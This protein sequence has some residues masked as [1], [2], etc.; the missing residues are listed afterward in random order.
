MSINKPKWPKPTLYKAK[1][2]TIE[3]KLKSADFMAPNQPYSGKIR[4]VEKGSAK[5]NSSIS[6]KIED[7]NNMSPTYSLSDDSPAP[8]TGNNNN[9]SGAGV[10]ASKGWSYKKYPRKNQ[11]SLNC[12]EI[13]LIKNNKLQILIDTLSNFYDLG[14]DFLNTLLPYNDLNISSRDM[15]LVLIVTGSLVSA[16]ENFDE[17]WTAVMDSFRIDLSQ[18]QQLEDVNTP[19][20]KKLITNF[21]ALSVLV[22]LING[23][24]YLDNIFIGHRAIELYLQQYKSI[25]GLSNSNMFTYIINQRITTEEKALALH[26]MVLFVRYSTFITTSNQNEKL[27]N[28]KLFYDVFLNS[29]FTYN[30]PNQSKTLLEYIQEI[31][32]EDVSYQMYTTCDYYLVTA[33]CDCLYFEHLFN[34]PSFE[35]KDQFHKALITIIKSQNEIANKSNSDPNS[36]TPLNPFSHLFMENPMYDFFTI[37]DR[38]SISDGFWILLEISWLE[39]INSYYAESNSQ[40][41]LPEPAVAE[42]NLEESED[43]IANGLMGKEHLEELERS[44]TL[45]VDKLSHLFLI[46]TTIVIS[47]LTSPNKLGLS[48]RNLFLLVD[49]LSFQ[50]NIFRIEITKITESKQFKDSL[51]NPVLKEFYSIWNYALMSDA[52]QTNAMPDRDL[53][54][55]QDFSRIYFVPNAILPMTEYSANDFAFE[56]HS[57]ILSSMKFMKFNILMNRLI[58][59]STFISQQMKNAMI[60]IWETLQRSI[61]QNWSAPEIV[62]KK[63]FSYPTESNTNDKKNFIEVAEDNTT[64]KTDKIILPPPLSMTMVPSSSQPLAYMTQSQSFNTKNSFLGTIGTSMSAT[65]S[66]SQR[67]GS[68][69][70]TSQ[71]SNRY[72]IQPPVS[73]FNIETA[74]QSKTVYPYETNN[75]NFPTPYSNMMFNPMTRDDSLS[76]SSNSMNSR[77]SMGTNSSSTKSQRSLSFKAIPMVERTESNY[78]QFVQN[79]SISSI[80]QYLGSNGPQFSNHKMS[81]TNQSG[82]SQSIPDSLPLNQKYDSNFGAQ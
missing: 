37:K 16:D 15:T 25:E 24:S 67:I 55:F 1:A 47:L 72:N 73:N 5:A 12:K 62:L 59:S 35:S 43:D 70:M 4:F 64:N 56:Y 31:N 80:N 81:A 11:F 22:F 65:N 10:N 69:A 44:D 58:T 61:T 57:F 17:I 66:I 30:P 34:N 6:A 14:M 77:I 76:I 18:D 32:Y 7:S 26:S 38:K 74:N 48:E 13:I 9:F 52:I 46:P 39:F 75:T 42:T 79:S 23:A 82:N 3:E 40:K 41:V 54:A 27:S 50:V 63:G 78:T 28:I 2:K 45:H 8:N 29:I 19:A 20:F 51:D 36:S 49:V 60:S 21:L 71:L 33:I 68:S 53:I